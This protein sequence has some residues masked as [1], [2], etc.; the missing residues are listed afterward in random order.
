MGVFP[1]LLHSFEAH[2]IGTT[3]KKITHVQTKY[4]NLVL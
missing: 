4:L 3:T 1:I 2:K